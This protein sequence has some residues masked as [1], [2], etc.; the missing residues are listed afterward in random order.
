MKRFLKFNS[1]KYDCLTSL[2][3]LISKSGFTLAEILITLGIIGVVAAMTIPILVSNY[4]KQQWATQLQ[5]SYTL[6]NQA[7]EQISLDYGCS[8][9]LTCTGLFDNSTD[10]SAFGNVITSYMKVSKNCALSDGL[11]C[12]TN[13][14][15][16]NY[17]GTGSPYTTYD[18]STTTY[19]F[20]AIDGV[21]MVITDYSNGCTTNLGAKQYSR[22]CGSVWFDV[23]GLKGPNYRGRDIFAFIITTG[24]NHGLLMPYGGNGQTSSDGLTDAYWQTG[25]Y[26][27]P[28]NPIGINCAGRVVERGW[29][30]DY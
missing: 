19:K 3:N 25:G 13:S 12:F 5:K 21:T 8:G 1:I 6:F 11:G 14:A 27:I 7:L 2:S 16:P 22:S 20:I 26:C 18:S 9:D 15:Q 30:E 28:S 4:Q 10:A 24:N 29:Q 17:D 23:N